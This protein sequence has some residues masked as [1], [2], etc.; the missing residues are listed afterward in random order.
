MDTQ[1]RYRLKRL[2]VF[3]NTAAASLPLIV[4]LG[5]IDIDIE[6]IDIEGGD[7]K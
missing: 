6:Y 2:H 5:H 1:Y 4:C 7:A 3:V